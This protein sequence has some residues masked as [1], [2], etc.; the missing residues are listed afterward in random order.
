MTSTDHGKTWS[1]PRKLGNNIRLGSRNTNLIGPVKNKPVE[2]PGGALL[3]PSSSEHNGWRV[4]CEISK[5]G[6]KS[7]EVIGPIHDGTKFGAIQPSVLSYGKGRL[8]IL[9][10]TRQNVVGQSWSEDGGKTWTA[11]SATNLPNPNAGTD[12][13]TLKDGRQLIVY[14]HTVRRGAFPAG[15][16][17]LNVA[18]SKTGEKWQPVLT[19]ERSR[20][21]YSYPAMI[22]TSDG[23]VHITYTYQRRTVKHVVLD[24]AKLGK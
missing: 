20:G 23:K 15:R 19:L 24:A 3:C 5:D 18:L 8:Q 16:N 7:W 1:K 2:L 11:V 14:N 17:M 13:V 10:R 6:G 21:E 9:C 12:A 4:H 22:Q